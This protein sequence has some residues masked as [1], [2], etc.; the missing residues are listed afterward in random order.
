[1]TQYPSPDEIA[2]HL[3]S[4]LRDEEK[5]VIAKVESA[6]GMVRF[7]S[8]VGM[9][10]RNRYRFWDADNPHTNASAAPNE[11]GIIDDPKFPDQVSHA[12]LES[13]WEMVQSERVL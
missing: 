13:V 1:M 12:I 4:E 6:A 9:F 10:I 5:E 8:T 11:K 2:K 7:H 3:F